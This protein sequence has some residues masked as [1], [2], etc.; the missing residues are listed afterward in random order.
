[1]NDQAAALR[2]ADNA[3]AASAPDGVAATQADS[4]QYLVAIGASAGGLEALE[5]LFADLPADTGS[6]FVVIQHLSSEHKS[7]MDSL[8]SRHTRMPVSIVEDGMQIAGNHVYLIP[9]GSV[10]HLEGHQ[11][12]LTPRSPRILTLPIDVFFQSMSLFFG[13]HAV[14]V[15]LSGTGSDG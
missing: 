15:V 6:A 9:P 4:S 13:D 11:L 3:Q 14:G 12:R 5:R 7:M 2:A 10:M 1:M 8:L